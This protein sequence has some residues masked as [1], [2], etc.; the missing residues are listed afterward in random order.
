[1]RGL[2]LM[3]PLRPSDGPPRRRVRMTRRLRR[4]PPRPEWLASNGIDGFWSEGPTAQHRHP[5]SPCWRQSQGHSARPLRPSRQGALLFGV[6]A[7]ATS[8]ARAAQHWTATA[9]LALASCGHGRDARSRRRCEGR[10]SIVRSQNPRGGP[11]RPQPSAATLGDDHAVMAL[12]AAKNSGLHVA[13]RDDEKSHRL[14]PALL[15]P[16]VGRVRLPAASRRGRLRPHRRRHLRVA[17]LRRVRGRPD[18]QGGE[19]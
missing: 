13:R 5:P 19:Y 14:H 9:T 12:R 17:A 4:R 8:S 11:L 15:P 10:G 7:T 1:M 3:P 2:L 16:V 6:F 18:P